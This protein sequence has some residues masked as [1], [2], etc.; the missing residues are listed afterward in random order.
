MSLKSYNKINSFGF[1][2][3]F[4]VSNF[5][6]LFEKNVLTQALEKANKQYNDNTVYIRL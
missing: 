5:W 6:K 4:L 2:T 3:G 1:I